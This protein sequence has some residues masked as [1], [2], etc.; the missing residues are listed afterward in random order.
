MR[1]STGRDVGILD[2]VHVDRAAVR[3]LRP[4]GR[5]VDVAA[6]ERRGVVG[7]DRLKI[8]A[9][10]RV[11]GDHAPDRESRSI[12][13]AED[14]D[15]LAGDVRVHDQAPETRLPVEAPVRKRQHPKIAQRHGTAG[16]PRDTG[17]ATRLRRV[18]TGDRPAERSLAL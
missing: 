9:P 15:D 13:R 1:R 3:V 14:A 11:D 10:E 17:H 18:D 4:A 6:V 12:E 8:A 7:L 5:P 16:A 2:R